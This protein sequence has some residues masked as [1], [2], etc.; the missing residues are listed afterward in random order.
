MFQVATLNRKPIIG[1]G[2]V[3][4]VVVMSVGIFFAVAHPLSSLQAKPTPIPYK[5]PPRSMEVPLATHRTQSQVAGRTTTTLN[6]WGVAIDQQSGYIWVA[7]PGCEM[8]P[9]C[10]PARTAILG[11]FSFADGTLIQEYQEPAGYSSPLFVA[12]GPDGNV[13]FT[14]PSTDAIGEF[15]PVTAS[16]SKYAVTKGSGPY[17]LIVDKN[18][19]L[20]F[21]EFTGNRIGFLNTQTHAVVET[22]I[23]T[24]DSNPYGITLDSQGTAWF[25]ENREG[26]G[27]LGSFPVTTSGKITITEHNVVAVQPHL[28]VVDKAGNVWF[29]EAFAGQ[30]GEYIPSAGTTRNYPVSAAI[31]PALA[32]CI[33]SHISGIALDKSGNVWFTDSLSG[34]VGYIV[35]GTGQLHAYTFA[36]KNLHPHDG[37]AIDKNNTVWFTEEYGPALVMWP[38]AKLPAK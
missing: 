37:L 21:S 29:S 30:I 16:F 28:L 38:G 31:C 15:N 9:V 12:V 23:P 3:A 34:R 36:T 7:E 27:R 26:V 33:G 14:Q 4:L 35:P 17:D 11:K 13:W 18:G 25:T 22:P 32:S 10:N 6:P 5:A 20:W 1:V 2:L 24:L 19:N 8:V